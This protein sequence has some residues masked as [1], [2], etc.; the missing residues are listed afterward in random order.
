MTAT[1]ATKSNFSENLHTY[2]LEKSQDIKKF[3]F[4]NKQ[5]QF[6]MKQ[7]NDILTVH[8]TPHIEIDD[9]YENMYFTYMKRRKYYI[10]LTAIL[11]TQKNI[12]KIL[13]QYLF[14]N[15]RRTKKIDPQ[16]ISPEE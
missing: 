5:E 3:K 6:H 12:K 9:S 14:K 1:P 16:T 15:R 2:S 4:N 10:I 13:Q 8:N 7:N 11:S